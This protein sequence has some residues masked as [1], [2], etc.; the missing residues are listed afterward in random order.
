MLQEGVQIK[1]EIYRVGGKSK[2]KL[3]VLFERMPTNCDWL[4]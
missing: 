1:L 2:T 3:T 4:I